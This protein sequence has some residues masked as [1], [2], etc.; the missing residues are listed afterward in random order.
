MEVLG[1]VFLFGF[2]KCG[3]FAKMQKNLWSQD[4]YQGRI[5]E[6]LAE[7]VKRINE[8]LEKQR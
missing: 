8:M 3:G 4:F 7:I 1:S 2:V 5:T 6:T